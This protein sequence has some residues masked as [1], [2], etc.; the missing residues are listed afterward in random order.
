MKAAALLTLLTLLAARIPGCQPPSPEIEALCR[1]S[2]ELACS[3][4]VCGVPVEIA[5]DDRLHRRDPDDPG[6]TACG[7]VLGDPAVEP[8]IAAAQLTLGAGGGHAACWR[9]VDV[10]VDLEDDFDAR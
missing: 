4:V 1:C 5:G 10:R 3:P 2:A 7:A 8:P 6:R 9:P